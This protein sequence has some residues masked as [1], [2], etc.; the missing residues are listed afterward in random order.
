MKFSKLYT[1][2]FLTVPVVAQAQSVQKLDEISV[3]ALRDASSYAKDANT[4]VT[5][6]HSQLA[7]E[8][9]ANVAQAV[10]NI[11]N[12]TV[13][14][15]E[16]AINQKPNIRGLTGNRVAQVIDGVKQN[17]ELRYRGSYFLPMSM[18][19]DVEVIKGPASTLWGNGALG[20]V[21]AMRTPTAMDL[22]EN[23][24]DVGAKLSQGYQSANHL[25]E[26][27]GLVYGANDS[28]DALLGGFYNHAGDM[29]L[30]DGKDLN[31]SRYIQKGGLAKLGWQIND[32]NRVTF[33]HRLTEISQT[34][35]NEGNML[36]AKDANDIYGPMMPS[37]SGHPGMGHQM[38]QGTGRPH[39]GTAGMQGH[40]QANPHQSAGGHHASAGQPS[41][42]GSSHGARPSGHGS[43]TSHMPA[44]MIDVHTAPL[45]K[46]KIS[47]QS[48][49]F[50]Y[51]FDPTDNDYVNLHTTLYHSRTKLTEDWVKDAKI[52]DKTLY[53]TTGINVRNSSDLGGVYL[54][55]GIDYAYNT[56]DADRPTN[57]TRD[58]K[59]RPNGY[60][61]HSRNT[62]AYLLAHIPL[63]NEKLIVSPSLRYDHFSAKNTDKVAGAKSNKYRDHH[64]SPSLA[65]TWH[66]TDF[67]T[68]HAKYNE[69]FR[70][71]TLQESFASG[72]MFSIPL[73]NPASIRSFAPVVMKQNSNLKPEVA[74]NK[75]LGADLHFSDVFTVNDKLTFSAG[76]FRN[77]IKDYIDGKV[78]IRPTYDP[79]KH[80]MQAGTVQ[81]VNIGKARLTGFEVATAYQTD[82][83]NFGVNYGE[84]RGKNL[85]T[86]ID[87]DNVP[88][89][90]LGVSLD[91][92]A[93]PNA[94]TLG[95]NVHRYA[96]Q[97]HVSKEYDRNF[98]DGTAFDG[99]TLTNIHAT[100]APKAG[101]LKNLRVDFAVD[102]LFDKAY[103]PAFS[104]IDGAG[105]N[106]KLNFAYKF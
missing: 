61:A 49:A 88:A 57:D 86:G 87:L 2:L 106:I 45:V 71:P 48:T 93:I 39:Q 97:R 10:K 13:D 80:K 73:G 11:P 22:L 103:R 101:S 85:A 19:E 56:A 23:G 82:R 92:V 30:G 54:T 59:Y 52:H 89:A 68:L 83:W 98:G 17:F 102:N 35:P 33:S 24:Q 105:R 16:R 26:T 64:Y 81:Y 29:R 55:Y 65:L 50:N 76:Y 74:R 72:E 51:T 12:V 43:A 69:A 90:K 91:Y 47:D 5:L 6:N 104:L 21:V 37:A 40:P 25:S 78:D 8:Q 75:E 7:S 20:G 38:G 84:T 14:G 94:L 3:V 62:G 18:I 32:E 70:A 100:Y 1:A 53:K 31:H 34:L 36:N 79:V 95:A 41:H 67:L 44:H 60:D 9:A 96:S 63:M 28:V 77:D 58:A 46:Q 15:G 4:V 99:Y 42:G 66:T 27:S